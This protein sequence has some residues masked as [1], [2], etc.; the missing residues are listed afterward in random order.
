MLNVCMQLEPTAYFLENEKA[1]EDTFNELDKYQRKRR[2]LFMLAFGLVYAKSN[3]C[4]HG[5][6]WLC[7]PGHERPSSADED[8]Q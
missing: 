2:G 4:D 7:A 3:K 6:L 5:M 8:T 1:S